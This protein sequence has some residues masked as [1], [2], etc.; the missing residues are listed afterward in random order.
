MKKLAYRLIVFDWKEI[1]DIKEIQKAVKSGYTNLYEGDT[2]GD[3]YCWILSK[4]PLTKKEVNNI[5]K[6]EFGGEE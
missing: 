5:I 2:G 4:K 6:K 1:P 3:E